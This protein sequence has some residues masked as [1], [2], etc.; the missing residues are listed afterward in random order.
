MRRATAFGCAV[1]AALSLAAVARSAQ[2]ALPSTGARVAAAPVSWADV[3]IRSVTAA[4]PFG[5]DPARFRPT[6]P[7][8]R[9]ELAAALVAWGKPAAVPVDPATP[10]T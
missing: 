1:L 8:T 4:G 7:L 6:D 3:Q 2:P 5:S 10:V 9:G